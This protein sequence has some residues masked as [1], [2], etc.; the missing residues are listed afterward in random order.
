[1]KKRK[2]LSLILSVM[3][4]TSVLFSVLS[5]VACGQ[6]VDP[7]VITADFN[8]YDLQDKTLKDLMDILVEKGE[9]EFESA[10][11]MINSIN[12]VSNTTNCY[13]MLY[14]DDAE[15]SSVEW[16][17]TEYNGKTYASAIYGY[18]QLSLKDGCTYIW[19]YEQF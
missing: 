8:E 18:E 12:K 17:T 2:N 15:L 11:G 7:V 10:N 13:W 16:G 5:F 14:T 19:V 6:K 4:L 3:M 1:M 9:L